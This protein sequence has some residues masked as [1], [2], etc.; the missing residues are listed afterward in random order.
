[1]VKMVKM[2]EVGKLIFIYTLVGFYYSFIG[3]GGIPVQF[4]Y[5]FVEEDLGEGELL[6]SRPKWL[7]GTLI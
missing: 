7:S 2:V 4:L 6:G 5:I 3:T 1:M